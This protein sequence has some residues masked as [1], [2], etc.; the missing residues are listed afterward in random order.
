MQAIRAIAKKKK[1]DLK[2]VMKLAQQN[3]QLYQN[4]IGKSL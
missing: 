1:P 3:L 4:I 2:A